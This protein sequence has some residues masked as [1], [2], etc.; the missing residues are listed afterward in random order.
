MNHMIKTKNTLKDKKKRVFLA[1]QEEV[2]ETWTRKG[3][4]NEP[5]KES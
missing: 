3:D 4:L 1:H 5:D 2:Q